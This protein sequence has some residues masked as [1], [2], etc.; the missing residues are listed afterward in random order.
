VVGSCEYGNEPSGHIIL[1][2]YRSYHINFICL[3]NNIYD[4]LIQLVKV[5][6]SVLSWYINS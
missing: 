2:I 6:S 5:S 1:T 3:D 4:H